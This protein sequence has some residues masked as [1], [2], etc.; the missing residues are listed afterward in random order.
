M[1]SPNCIF[2]LLKKF[3]QLSIWPSK[4]FK[5]SKVLHTGYLNTPDLFQLATSLS[6]Y[7]NSRIS[8]LRPYDMGHIISKV[9]KAYVIISPGYRLIYLFVDY[10]Y[11][12]KLLKSSMIKERPKTS[13]LELMSTW[14]MIIYLKIRLWSI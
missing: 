8:R 12:T 10:L 7:I 13:V 5:P 14:L 6:I 3:S 11:V 2:L 4:K 9:H 1:K